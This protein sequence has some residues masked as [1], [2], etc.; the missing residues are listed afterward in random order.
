MGYDTAWLLLAGQWKDGC[1]E[2]AALGLILDEVSS[3]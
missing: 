3:R 2:G 1:W